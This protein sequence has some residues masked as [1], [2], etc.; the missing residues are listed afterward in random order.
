GRTRH[1]LGGPTEPQ[2]P[3]TMTALMHPNLIGEFPFDPL[4]LQNIDQELTELESL[5]S[6]GIESRATIQ[7]LVVMMANHRDATSRRRDDVVK[8]TKDVEKPFRQ[9]ARFL[10]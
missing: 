7:V 1:Q 9:R 3:Q 5:V 2:F 6:Q 10:G 4:N 8:R